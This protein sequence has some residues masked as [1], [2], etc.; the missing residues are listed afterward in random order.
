VGLTAAQAAE[1]IDATQNAVYRLIAKGALAK[2][3]KHQHGGLQLEAVEVTS[4][5]RYRPSRPHP[6]WCRSREAAKIL[7]FST[8]RVQQLRCIAGEG[9]THARS[10]KGRSPTFADVERWVG[11]WGWR[12]GTRAG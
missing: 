2:P 4:L 7:G 10:N 1:I 11:Y 9:P 3:V 8:A 5:Q 12:F 6:Y